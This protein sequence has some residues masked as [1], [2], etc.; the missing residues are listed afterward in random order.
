MRLSITS[1]FGSLGF[2]ATLLLLGATATS[3]GCASTAPQSQA[4]RQDLR[5]EA[6]LAL[7]K[8]TREDSSLRNFLNNKAHA[9]VVF[10]SIG[11]GGFLVGGAYG[12]G[13]VFRGD[14]AIGYGVM[15]QANLGLIIGA[16]TFT[17]ILTFERE[18]DLNEFMNRGEYTLAANA[19]AIF[20]KAGVAAKTNF[21]NG[22]AVF[23]KPRGGLIADLSLAGQQFKFSRTEPAD[24]QGGGGGGSGGRDSTSTTQP[25]D[26]RSGGGSG[27][28]NNTRENNNN[29]DGGGFEAE[30]EV[31]IDTNGGGGGGSGQ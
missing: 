29:R 25:A 9:Y 30:A 19:T 15:N 31:D 10:P 22:V 7:R 13:V 17:E 11:K 5:D 18:A 16:N 23:V 3:T 20:L 21:Q 1:R 14:Q 4:A 6:R 26:N 2:T 24:E 28:G 12:R 8:M 27:S